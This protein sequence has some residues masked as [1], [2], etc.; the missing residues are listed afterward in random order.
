MGLSRCI[1]VILFAPPIS[2]EPSHLIA[3]LPQNLQPIY[4]AEKEMFGSDTRRDLRRVLAMQAGHN[5]V[6]E[7]EV[8]AANTSLG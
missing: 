3:C 7:A 6:L 4:A 2:Q 5:A 1:V 8:V